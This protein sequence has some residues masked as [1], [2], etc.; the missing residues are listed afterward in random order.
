MA[1]Q[2]GPEQLKKEQEVTLRSPRR[3][4]GL[5]ASLLFVFMD[6]VY[7]KRKNLSKFKV[8][9]V[10]ARVPYQAW[11]HAAYVAI[12]HTYSKPDFARRIFD[13]VSDFS[14]DYGS[15]DSAA[16]LF[17]RIALDERH[18]KEESLQRIER[19]RFS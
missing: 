18:H 7:G 15:F 16:D 17:R 14:K 2:P 10:I 13:F 9:E 6:L 19:A 8:L 12:T 4:Y 5:A 11:E 1:T 3:R